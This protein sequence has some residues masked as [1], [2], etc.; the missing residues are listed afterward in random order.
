MPPVSPTPVCV[1]QRRRR[2]GG[3]GLVRAEHSQGKGPFPFEP[4]EYMLAGLHY[5]QA[6]QL[7]GGIQGN[8]VLMRQQDEEGRALVL[9]VGGDT[10]LCLTSMLQVCLSSSARDAL[11]PFRNARLC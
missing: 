5:I 11:S 8:L 3:A 4:S 7:A 1:T 6:A 2:L 9:G 10:L